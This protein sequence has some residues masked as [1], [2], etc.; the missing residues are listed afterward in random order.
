M[1]RKLAAILAADV[2][3]YAR[4]MGEDEVGT[5]AALEAPRRA[6]RSTIAAHR[7]RIVKL[8]GD[9]LLA[10]FASVAGMLD[11]ALDPAR[12]GRAQRRRGRPAHRLRIGINLG[13]VIAEKD[14]LFGDGVNIAARLEAC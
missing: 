4:L 11:A 13:D 2:V 9:G 8:M 6:D 7:G 3:G 5:H 12:H 1:E 10:E 14:D